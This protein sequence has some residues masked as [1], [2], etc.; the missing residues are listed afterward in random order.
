MSHRKGEEETYHG[1]N[2]LPTFGNDLR[3]MEDCNINDF[4][5]SNV[6]DCYEP[7]KDFKKKSL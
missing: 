7:P 2:L 6:G 5:F 3:I 1:Y 4:S